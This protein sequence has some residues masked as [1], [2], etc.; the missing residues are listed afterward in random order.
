MVDQC[1]TGLKLAGYFSFRFYRTETLDSVK[2][3]H[4]NTVL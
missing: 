2:S 1:D 3:F 4:I